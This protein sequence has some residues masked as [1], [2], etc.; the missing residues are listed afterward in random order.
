[1]DPSFNFTL[2]VVENKVVPSQFTGGKKIGFL[3]GHHRLED[4]VFSLYPELKT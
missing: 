3:L 1:M 2:E 4:S